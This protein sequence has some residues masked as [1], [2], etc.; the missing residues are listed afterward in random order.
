MSLRVEKT[1]GKHIVSDASHVTFAIVDRRATFAIVDRRATYAIVDRKL[2][3][4][5]NFI[6]IGHAQRIAG[7]MHHPISTLTRKSSLAYQRSQ[8]VR[9]PLLLLADGLTGLLSP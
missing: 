3:T 7:R 4:S 5:I 1:P 6:S 2:V 8:A 9:R